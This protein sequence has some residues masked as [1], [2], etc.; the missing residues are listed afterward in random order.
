M[1]L[2]DKHR[3]F[4]DEYLKDMN[5]AAAYLRAGYNCTESA[6]RVNASK[7]LTNANISAYIAT[8]QEEIAK[9]S[10]ISV[11]WVLDN[12]KYVAERCLTPEPMVDRE[13]NIIEWRFD[14]SGANKAL[15]TI[16]KHLG[17]FKEKIEHSGA[18]AHTHKHDLKKLSAK[19]LAQL[20]QIIGKS[21][22]TG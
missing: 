10:G 4:A 20:E 7:L 19:E 1:A 6:A 8:K 11:K 16:G 22:D 15:E 2:S 18:I 17:M 3:R 21:A 9:E 14:S 5:G 13:G 12:L